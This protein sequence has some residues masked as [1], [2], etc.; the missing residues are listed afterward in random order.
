MYNAADADLRQRLPNLISLLFSLAPYILRAQVEVQNRMLAHYYTVL[1]AFCEEEGLPSPP[2]SMDQVAQEW[3]Y[4]HQDARERIESLNCLV[5][6][7]AIRRENEA[8]N[9]NQRPSLGN[10]TPSTGT[11]SS[12]ASSLRGRPSMAPP[13][14]APKPCGR[15][16]R[17]P[18]PASS[19]F[20]P[21]GSISVASS[22]STHSL[23]SGGD[24]YKP[25]PPVTMP[26]PNPA[27]S[28]V[29]T[30]FIQPA[31]P[32]TGIRMQPAGPNVDHFQLNHQTKAGNTSSELA[33][34]IKR[35]RPPPPPAASKPVFV[36]AAYDF[37][38]Q[39]DELSFREGDRIRVTRK[40]ASNDD[41]WDGELNGVKGPFPANYIE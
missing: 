24:H 9:Q 27:P 5:Q 30:P 40:T 20:T 6:G 34:M 25:P 15:E 19:A 26:K 7:K 29:V 31:A 4:A 39:G 17:S 18:S 2:P 37:Q 12:V 22:A 14:L 3:E 41:W 8:Q 11:T 10:R 32:P 16:T 33:H 36:T 1:N 38:G 13:F 28:P 23:P 35:K 21:R